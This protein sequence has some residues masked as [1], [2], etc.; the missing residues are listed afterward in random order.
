MLPAEALRANGDWKSAFFKG[1]GQFWPNFHIEGEGKWPFCVFDPFGSL[2]AM[3]AVHLELTG[4]LVVDFL[5][6]LIELF[7][8]R[9]MTEAL[10]VNID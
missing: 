7:L 4:K 2:G 3:Y 6:V 5:L 8:P 9:V 1:V 10:R